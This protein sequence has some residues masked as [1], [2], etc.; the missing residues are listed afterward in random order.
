[1]SQTTTTTKPEAQLLFICGDQSGSG[2]TSTCI[3]LINAL[4]TQGGY[5]PQEVAYIKPCTQC[6]GV[7][8]LWKF[9]HSLG[10]HCV[11]IGPIVYKAGYTQKCIN[12]ENGTAEERLKLVE[13]AVEQLKTTHKFILIDG[14]GYP[15]VGSCVGCSNRDVARRLNAPVLMI[16]RPGVGNMIDSCVMNVEYMAYKDVITIGTIVNK[17]PKKVSYHTPEAIAE[18]TTK[19]FTTYRYTTNYG[20]KEHQLNI[21]GYI[22]VFGGDG[23]DGSCATS[24]A[25][26]CALKPNVDI[27]TF[28]LEMDSVDSKELTQLLRLHSKHIDYQQLFKDVAA[29]NNTQRE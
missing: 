7:Q 24:C 28:D 2:K 1:M 14:V 4:I 17:V 22:P 18:F 19:F 5:Q 21:Y 13:D 27:T 26:S 29:A 8:L 3:G 23:D 9:C 10:V 16:S 25:T 15:G 20:K 12:G 11:G 6:E